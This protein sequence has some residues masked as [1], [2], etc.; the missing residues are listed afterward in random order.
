M[1]YNWFSPFFF[2][3]SVQYKVKGDFVYPEEVDFHVDDNDEE[4]DA[5][6][7]LSMIDR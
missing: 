7:E 5:E 6:A 3:L 1:I 4:Y 2:S